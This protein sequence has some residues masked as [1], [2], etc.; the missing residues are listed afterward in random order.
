MQQQKPSAPKKGKKKNKKGDVARAKRHHAARLA[1]LEAEVAV[2]L[3]FSS[4]VHLSL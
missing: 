2:S 1:A 4:F 3:P